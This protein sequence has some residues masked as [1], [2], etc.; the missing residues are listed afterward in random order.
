MLFDRRN[1]WCSMRGS[2]TRFQAATTCSQA[3]AHEHGNWIFSLDEFVA[4][5][6][7]VVRAEIPLDVFAWTEQREPTAHRPTPTPPPRQTFNWSFSARWMT[8]KLFA[9]SGRESVGARYCPGNIVIPLEL[10]GRLMRSWSSSLWAGTRL[11]DRLIATSTML[12]CSAEYRR[13]RPCFPSECL[14]NRF[15]VPRSIDE[16]TLIRKSHYHLLN[17]EIVFN[18]VTGASVSCDLK[19]WL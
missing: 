2:G 6:G 1:Y 15:D 9:R 14:F 10:S 7:N 12:R 16:D 5:P 3:R 18:D 19:H 13:F 8:W 11:F 4:A 17:G